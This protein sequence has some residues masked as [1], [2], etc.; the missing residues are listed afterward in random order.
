MILKVKL[1]FYSINQASIL[2]FYVSGFQMEKKEEIVSSKLTLHCLHL[3]LLLLNTD[4]YNNTS[5]MEGTEYLNWTQTDKFHIDMNLL[6]HRNDP[7]LSGGFL[8]L[9]SLCFL[10]NAYDSLR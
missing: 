4:N 7:V 8:C 10:H 9:P 5:V 3:D 2:S 6:N 1:K